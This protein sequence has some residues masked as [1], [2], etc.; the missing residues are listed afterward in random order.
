MLNRERPM[1]VAM[2]SV[3]GIFPSDKFKGAGP[4]IGDAALKA[5]FGH[6]TQLDFGHIQPSAMRRRVMK[7]PALPNP[8]SFGLTKGFDEGMI[9]VGGAIVQHDLNTLS[10]RV[11]CI[12][13]IAHRIGKILFGSAARDEG[14]AFASFGFSKHKDIAR[15][16]ALIFRVFAARMSRL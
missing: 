13:Q 14:M 8:V 2:G 10:V 11:E 12:Q 6:D 4:L 15:A 1:N 7:T 3:G 5:W 9:G 16:V